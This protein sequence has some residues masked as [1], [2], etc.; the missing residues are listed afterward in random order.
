MRKDLVLCAL[1][2]QILIFAFLYYGVDNFRDKK[3]WSG[4]VQVFVNGP[5]TLFCFCNNCFRFCLFVCLFV[6]ICLFCFFVFVCLFVYFLFCFC[7]CFCFFF[8]LFVCLFYLFIYF[9][10]CNPSL[11]LRRKWKKAPDY[12][13]LLFQKIRENLI[14]KNGYR[15]QPYIHIPRRATCIS[16]WIS[17]S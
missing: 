17:S 5:L 11:K 8:C 14:G 13:I 6:L 4:P 9:F 2:K 3:F 16:G 10:C 15:S 1:N 7:F 12:I